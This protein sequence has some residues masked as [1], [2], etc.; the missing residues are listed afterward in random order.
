[1]LSESTSYL[2]H[3]DTPDLG[4]GGISPREAVLKQ[5]KT[6]CED[7]GRSRPA[8]R[9][10]AA[11][12]A[13]RDRRG[14]A[15]LCRR[16][17]QLRDRGRTTRGHRSVPGTDPRDALE[18]AICSP[19]PNVAARL[20]RRLRDRGVDVRCA[21]PGPPG[22]V[23]WAIEQYA[24]HLPIAQQ[25]RNK[26]SLQAQTILATLLA[27]P[28]A[29]IGSLGCG[30]CRDLRMV[31]GYIPRGSG[32]LVLVDG[33]GD[34]LAYAREQLPMLGDRCRTVRGRV[35]RVLPTLAVHGPFD[36]IIAGGLFDYL[37]DRWAIA[38]LREVRR[39]LAPSGRVVF[40]NIASGNPFRQWLEYL[41]DWTLI[42]RSHG[43]LFRLLEAAEFAPSD[44]TIVSDSTGL[45]LMM[46]AMAGRSTFRSPGCKPDR[47]PDSETRLWSDAGIGALPRSPSPPH[48][49]IRENWGERQRI[50]EEQ[51][52]G[53]DSNG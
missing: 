9:A 5:L 27:N 25:H 39:L 1:M 34:A 4:R 17:R 31:Q 30:G 6:A 16:H 29:R 53:R 8:L 15:H 18:V 46:S 41:A 7:I 52:S 50:Y 32:A 23:A 33:D 35:P 38:T 47:A 2:V 51:I 14:D 26:V 20:S 44:S 21:E 24:L 12:V 49:K 45:A 48:R 42:E 11:A 19:A 37:P 28:D 40:S 10:L 22:T 36:L 3:D 43:D 13:A